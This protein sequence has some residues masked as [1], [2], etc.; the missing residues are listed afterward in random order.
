MKMKEP[1]YLAGP[2]RNPDPIQKRKNILHAIEIAQKFS[3]MGIEFY[4]P[5]TEMALFD[6]ACPKVSDGF[7]LSN[8]MWKLQ[9]CKSIYLM[10][11]WL[12]SEGSNGELEMAKA[13]GLEIYF[14]EKQEFQK[15]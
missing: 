15:V 1:V 13:W 2:Y 8:G 6:E 9:Y 14:E 7:W 10:K 11:G 4:S 3:S 12:H 5:I